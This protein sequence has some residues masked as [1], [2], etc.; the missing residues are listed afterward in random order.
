MPRAISVFLYFY[1]LNL[2]T[3]NP[4]PIRL[5][6]PDSRAG[7]LRYGWKRAI[8]HLLAGVTSR[9]RVNVIRGE[10]SQLQETPWVYVEMQDDDHLEVIGLT[11]FFLMCYPSSS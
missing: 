4:G 3:R 1:L 11:A 9:C 6:Q 7:A 8:H 5:T 2:A 10:E